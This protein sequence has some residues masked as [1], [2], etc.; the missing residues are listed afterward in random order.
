MNLSFK[1]FMLPFV[2]SAVLL[3]QGCTSQSNYKSSAATMNQLIIAE[4]LSINFKTELAIANYSDFLIR[5][6]LT[7]KQRAKVRFDRGLLYDS[8]GLR[9]L[10]RI[11]F[12]QAVQLDTSLAKAYN[13]LGIHFIQDQHFSQAY[14]K[15]DAALEIDPNQEYARL[16]RG[17]ALYYGNRP[18]LA[19]DDF[20]HF[21][22]Q[23]SEDPYRLLWLYFAE[24]D[25]DAVNAKKNLKQR[26]VFISD[27]TWAKQ[28]I[29]LYL[30]EMNQAQF[31]NKLTINVKSNKELTERLCEAYFY[32]GKY[33]LHKGNHRAA[34]SFFKLSL[35]TNVYEFVEHRYARLELDLMRIK[36]ANK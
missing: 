32:L 15:F 36:K 1:S 33:N 9:S 24:V 29:R 2:I 23:K 7:N 20:I 31:I 8:V 11:D 17:I 22:Q 18:E 12:N 16:N 19:A 30:D 13:F 35:G 21:H 27:R 26:S 6:K 4:P 14:E 28:V 3:A 10:A 5:A 25:F 34:A